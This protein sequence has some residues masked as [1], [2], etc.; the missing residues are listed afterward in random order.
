M[1]AAFPGSKI[2]DQWGGESLLDLQYNMTQMQRNYQGA[3]MQMRMD[4]YGFMYGD[5][6]LQTPG[7]YYDNI[8]QEA[9]DQGAG[10]GRMG[11]SAATV[12][13]IFGAQ[14]AAQQRGLDIRRVGQ[15]GGTL[16]GQSFTGSFG[17]ARAQIG[18]QRQQFAETHALS[19]AMMEAQRGMQVQ[20]RAWQ[21]EDIQI[22]RGR[23]RTQFG[24]QRA[25]MQRG[26]ARGNVQFGWRAEDLNLSI[27]QAAAGDQFQDWQMGF[28]QQQQ[29]MRRGWQMEDWATAR[30]TNQMQFGWQMEDMEENIRFSSGR[31]REQLVKQQERATTMQNLTLENFDRQEERAREMWDM[32]DE[33]FDRQIENIDRV[34]D[35][36]D[37]SFDN[38][39]ERLDEQ[40]EWHEE[41]FGIQMERF[42]IRKGW[43]EEDWARQLSRIEAQKGHENELWG[44]QTAR[45]GMELEHF[46]ESTGLQAAKL[47]EEEA[48]ARFQIENA[49]TIQGLQNQIGLYRADMMGRELTNAQEMQKAKYAYDSAS[50]M[51]RQ[52]SRAKD[53]GAFDSYTRYINMVLAWVANFYGYGYP[54]P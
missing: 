49:Q 26:F 27:R 22:A 13:G 2:F 20:Q 31:G 43:Q 25:D 24:W 41:D 21:V 23:G 48:L 9:L 42:E 29:G 3:A 38:Q 47:A 39:M 8:P 14:M 35:F 46:N 30:A 15:L 28:Q 40:R 45:H 16:D 11:V 37:E 33:A 6:A 7:Q 1:Q 51:F 12:G 18:L 54:N 17:F 34:R 19:G 4:E 5:A 44:L 36:R 32:E 52:L 10:R 53:N 50:E